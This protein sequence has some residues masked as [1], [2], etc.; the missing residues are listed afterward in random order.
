MFYMFCISSHNKI[1]MRLPV[2]TI[3]IQNHS[4]TESDEVSGV[5]SITM[6]GLTLRGDF[7]SNVARRSSTS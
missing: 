5:C 6:R 2:S 1:D 3:Y 7:D 4:C